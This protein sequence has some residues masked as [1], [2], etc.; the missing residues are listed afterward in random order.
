M[1]KSDAVTGDTRV[2][3]SE[4]NSPDIRYY[5]AE[6]GGPEERGRL[7]KKLLR[8]IDTRMSILVVIYILNYVSLLVKL[9]WLSTSSFRF[10][11]W[12]SGSAQIR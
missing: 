8:K 7:E 5:D 10:H 11:G 2:E 4:S 3:H 9:I 1:M 6:F 12:S